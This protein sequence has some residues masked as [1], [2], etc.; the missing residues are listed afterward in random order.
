MAKSDTISKTELQRL[1]DIEAAARLREAL[2]G[3]D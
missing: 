2:G 1:R 3:F